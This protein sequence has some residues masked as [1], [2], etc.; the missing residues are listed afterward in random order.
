MTAVCIVL[1]Y[2]DNTAEERIRK[3]SGGNQLTV[4]VD[5]TP[6]IE[7]A[8][9]SELAEKNPDVV[10]LPQKE[11]TGIAKAQNTGIGYCL[12]RTDISH[13]LFL[14]QD[15]NPEPDF[16]ERMKHAYL[17]C[18][19]NDPRLF[20]LGAT[21]INARN[22]AKYGGGNELRI[23][24]FTD[25]DSIISAGSMTSTENIRNTGGL[26]SS[27]FI[28]LVDFEWCFRARAEGKHNYQCSTCFLEHTIGCGDTYFLGQ[29]FIHSTPVRTYY[30]FR[31]SIRL[32]KRK[33]I[34]FSWKIRKLVW[35][36]LFPLQLYTWEKREGIL[37]YM[38]RGI[39]DGLK[40]D[41]P[42]IPF[43]R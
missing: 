13:I 2:P 28:D 20:L 35:L 16:P 32:I 4:L 18:Q 12:G 21:A 39:L 5:N 14:D 24:T 27:L 37:K 40:R 23:N 19:Q 9:F 11:N 8:F 22:N 7:H 15:S 42:E 43:R 38:F 25:T 29:Y 41:V 34:P 1:Y 30:V 36:A 3:L 17:Q 31:N 26:D 33:Y 6:D 10:Y